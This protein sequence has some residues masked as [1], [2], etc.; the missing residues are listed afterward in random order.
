MVPSALRRVQP[1]LAVLGEVGE[2]VAPGCC[3]RS[4]TAAEPRG[5]ESMRCAYAATIH[6]SRRG[7]AHSREPGRPRRPRHGYSEAA[8]PWALVAESSPATTKKTSSAMLVAWS[9]CARGA[10]RSASAPA[11]TDDGGISR[12][13]VRQGGGRPDPRRVS[14]ASSRSSTRCAR[15]RCV[16]EASRT[17]AA[18]PARR[19]PSRQHVVRES[20]RVEW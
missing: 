7:P 4:A 1:V 5:A 16:D 17:T 14:R 15:R 19:P 2:D 11:P 3:A 13:G 6:D 18:S 8:S 9:R 10:E 12:H 20:R